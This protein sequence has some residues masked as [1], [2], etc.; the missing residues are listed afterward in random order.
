MKRFIFSVILPTITA[1]SIFAA[2]TETDMRPVTLKAGNFSGIASNIPCKIILA[3]NPDSAGMIAFNI[4]PLHKDLFSFSVNN[5]VLN[6]AVKKEG[7]FTIKQGSSTYTIH[8]S[9]S[10]TS[11][12]KDAFRKKA[13]DVIYMSTIIVYVPHKLDDITINGSGTIKA[14]SKIRLGDKINLCVNGSGDI[15]LKDTSVSHLSASVNGSGDIE[16]T[17][18]TTATILESAVRGS[19][20]I[21]IKALNAD[22]LSADVYGSGD[23]E[24]AG[25]AVNAVYTVSGSGDIDCDKVKATSVTATVNGSGSIDCYAS[26][27][28]SGNVLKSG[29]IDCLGS[30]ANVSRSGKTRHISVH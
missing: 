23:I 24:I 3:N 28:F 2:K 29:N 19:G 30:P 7:S 15:K 13:K 1:L 8:Q 27:D 12:Y 22:K 9:K 6:C 21:D 25:K 10:G 26:R 14:G 17:G 16:L 20:D 11:V 18:N 5:G 4:S